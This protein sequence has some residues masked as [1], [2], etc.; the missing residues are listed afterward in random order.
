MAL[1]SFGTLLD[2]DPNDFLIVIPVGCVGT[3]VQ[4]PTSLLITSV[5]NIPTITNSSY[6]IPF[7]TIAPT[8]KFSSK[9]EAMSIILKYNLELNLMSDFVVENF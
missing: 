3:P 4:C 9:T 5:S 7:T 2:T 1:K 6:N 8:S